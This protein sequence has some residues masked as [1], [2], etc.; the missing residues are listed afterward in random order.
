MQ[1]WLWSVGANYKFVGVSKSFLFDVPFPPRRWHGNLV[2]VV[3]LV[4][5]KALQFCA[6]LSLAGSWWDQLIRRGRAI[7]R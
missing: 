1:C 3:V 6:L 7:S 5:E 4:Y 2:L